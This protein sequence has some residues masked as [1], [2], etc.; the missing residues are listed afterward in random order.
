MEKILL[1]QIGNTETAEIKRLAEGK[2]IKVISVPSTQFGYSL[3]ELEHGISDKPAREITL[4][5]KSLIL[6]CH[7]SEKHFDRLLFEMKSRKIPV[8]FKAVLTPTNQNWTID[9]LYMELAFE[10][11]QLLR[12][13]NSH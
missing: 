11:N 12:E 8:D 2:K 6:F 3:K 13:N 4:P 5:K 7:V 10:Q 1:F 9:R